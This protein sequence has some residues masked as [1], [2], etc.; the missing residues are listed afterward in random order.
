[1]ASLQLTTT[2]LGVG[3]SAL[4]LYLL[5]RDRLHLAHGLFWIAVAGLAAFF[6]LWPGLIDLIAR[7]VNIAYPPSLLL[8]GASIVLLVKSLH[9]DII[10]TRMERE[11]RRLNQRLAIYELEHSERRA[12]DLEQAGD[13]QRVLQDALPDTSLQAREGASTPVYRPESGPASPV[14]AISLVRVAGG[15]RRATDGD[16]A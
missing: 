9:A 1:M 4:I 10:N 5:R 8:L 14:E 11:I 3:L 16:E 13:R 6:G 15:R 7:V 12:N 2:L